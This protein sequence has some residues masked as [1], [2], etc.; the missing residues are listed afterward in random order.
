M[1]VLGT[2]AAVVVLVGF[3]YFIYRKVTAKKTTTNTGV[4]GGGGKGGN[5][6]PTQSK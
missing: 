6:P 5:G 2:I 3:G 4:G 1:D